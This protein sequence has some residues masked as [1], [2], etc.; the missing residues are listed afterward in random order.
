MPDV[1][2][3]AAEYGA[4]ALLILTAGFADRGDEGRAL[5]ERVL[6]IVR[7]A[8][9]RMV[10]PNCLGVLNTRPCGAPQR[11]VRRRDACPPAASR[12]ARSPAPS[13]SGCSGTRRRRRLGVS[14]FASLGDSADVSTN[15]LLELWEEDA[16]DGTR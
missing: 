8:G 4:K 16:A 11:H 9:L 1:A 12:S 2:A 14:S 3:Q 13:V 15:D 6:E 7:G 10:G 5:E